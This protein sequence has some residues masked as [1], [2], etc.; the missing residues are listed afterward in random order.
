M[1]NI[2][3]KIWYSGNWRQKNNDTIPY[4]GIKIKATPH[5]NNS[6]E[7]DSVTAIVIDFT[8]VPDGVSSTVQ[9]STTGTWYDIS[10]PMDD[11]TE[12]PQPNNDFTVIGIDSAD[13]L[14]KLQLY[15]T[16]TGVYLRVQFQYGLKH[17]R[18]QELGF[19]LQ[20]DVSLE[21]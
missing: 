2:D 21:R 14:G 7:L 1:N 16:T 9:L 11:S 10:I 3:N 12:P 6:N 8:K 5:Y 15:L 13:D 19:I 20:F 17:A 18:H 4:N